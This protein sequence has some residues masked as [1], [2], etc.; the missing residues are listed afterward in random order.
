MKA[1]TAGQGS[2]AKGSA[3]AEVW[4]L[5]PLQEGLL[6][7]ADFDG[8]GRP[9]IYTVQSVLSVDGPLDA[10]RLR[11]A[12][13]T[14]LDRHPAL[15]ASFHRRATGEAVQLIMREATLPWTEADL[16]DRTEPA[17]DAEFDRLVRAERDR[18]IDP[19]VAPLLRLLLVRRDARHHRLV[20]TSHHILL[21]GWSLPVL[22]DE[23]GTVYEAKGDPSSLAPVTSYRDY[24]AW[25][26]RQDKEA[27]RAA[28]RAELDGA[29]EPT[30]VAATATAQPG[31]GSP[32]RRSVHLCAET[33]AALTDLARARGLT[34]NTVVQGAWALVLARL[35]GR[36]DVVFGA[37]VAGRPPE[38]P[39]AETAVGLFI[40]TVPVRVRLD[41]AQ[42]LDRMLAELQDRQGALMAHQHLGLA[43]IQ[44][45]VGPAA[46]FDT[47]L[48]YENYPRSRRPAPDPGAVT[49]SSLE[50]RQ[51]THYPLSVGIAPD[52]RLRVDVTYHPG[53]IE[54]QLGEALGG[55]VARV[56]EQLAQDPTAPVG[57]LGVLTGPERGL[58]LEGWGATAGGVPG[59]L[60]PE[61][62]AGRVRVSPGAVALSEGDLSMT[63]EELWAASG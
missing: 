50:A 49:F 47:L 53:L 27:A 16:S 13:Q 7:H 39:G 12:W 42:P 40:N 10:A 11:A 3:L 60:V 63:Y 36:T 54:E 18:R 51:A 45:A 41:G 20:L 19:A 4:P 17:A 57:R 38:L 35:T 56:L 28:W 24:L 43:D 5:S 44:G 31:S 6:F 55:I 46:S 52:E 21:D 32:R 25:L 30:L 26:A 8:Q 14:L 59:G 58:V 22:L 29:E 34:L 2:T 62:V 33:T 61:L 9:D 48:V 23:L 37:T 15:R 1:P